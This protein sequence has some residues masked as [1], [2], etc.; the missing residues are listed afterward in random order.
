M[1]RLKPPVVEGVT[2]IDSSPDS[3]LSFSRS[4][5]PRATEDDRVLSCGNSNSFSREE[6]G[7]DCTAANISGDN[8]GMGAES[9]AIG[10][11]VLAFVK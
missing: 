2:S 5:S 10:S 8:R 1:G 7:F 4:L 11:I 9:A 3:V 6:V